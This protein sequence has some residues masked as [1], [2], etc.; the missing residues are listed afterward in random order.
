MLAD[1]F[2]GSDGDIITAAVKLL[3]LVLWSA[4]A[5]GR[6]D[7]HRGIPGTNWSTART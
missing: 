3:G 5:P 7:R 6:G 2:A 1:E 4:P